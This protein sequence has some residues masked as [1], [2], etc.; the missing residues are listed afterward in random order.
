MPQ[1]R[2]S[3]SFRVTASPGIPEYDIRSDPH[4]GAY[5]QKLGKRLLRSAGRKRGGSRA[6][7]GKRKRRPQSK[8]MKRKLALDAVEEAA[9]H[10]LSSSTKRTK[11]LRPMTA[12]GRQLTPLQRQLRASADASRPGTSPSPSKSS[13]HTRSTPTLA[14][15]VTPKR[16]SRPS[17]AI[18]RGSAGGMSGKARA[19]ADVKAR[20]ARNAAK[21]KAHMEVVMKIQAQQMLYLKKTKVEKQRLQSVEAEKKLLQREID[22]FRREL[23]GVDAVADNQRKTARLQHMLE[24]RI[25]QTESRMMTARSKAEKRKA[26]V[27]RMREDR[28]L[29][30]AAEHRLIADVKALREEIGRRRSLIKLKRKSAKLVRRRVVSLQSEHSVRTEHYR[31]ILDAEPVFSLEDAMESA[32]DSVLL[33]RRGTVGGG[34]GSGGGVDVERSLRERWEKEQGEAFTRH[35]RSSGAHTEAPV[36]SYQDAFTAISRATGISDLD[37]FMENFRDLEN[38]NYERFRQI[39]DLAAEADD[40]EVQIQRIVS[41]ILRISTAQSETESNRKNIVGNMDK[42]IADIKELSFFYRNR[43]ADIRGEAERYKAAIEKLQDKFLAES[44]GITWGGSAGFEGEPLTIRNMPQVLGVLEQ[45]ML[46][47]LHTYLQVVPRSEWGDLFSEGDAAAAG[48]ATA[49][50]SASAADGGVSPSSPVGRGRSGD[51][52]ESKGEDAGSSSSPPR[53]DSSLS[54]SLP[55][56]ATGAAPAASGGT[57]RRRRSRRS[58]ALHTPFSMGPALPPGS[59]VLRVKPPSMEHDGVP[60]MRTAAMRAVLTGAAVDAKPKL[61]AARKLSKGKSTAKRRQKRFFTG[62]RQTLVH[63]SAIV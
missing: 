8:F 9:K 13:L 4:M 33:D 23:G 32:K 56:T 63:R 30:T 44:A 41:D 40:L 14:P 3:G 29:E 26:I 24:V 49:V 37:S 18:T 28:L 39:N 12:P 1:R 53:E 25:R 17:T 22:R 15:A 2:Q 59:H 11:R 31:S 45:R 51:G 36:H 38:G 48:G 62:K 35:I 43:L 16:R 54:V 50:S 10:A 58:S 27:T 20:A 6:A 46:E 52:G 47:I 7:K 5:R 42:Q 19:E 21:R 61:P 34:G 57:G 60:S 55:S